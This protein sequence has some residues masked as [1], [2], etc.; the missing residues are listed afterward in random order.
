[1]SLPFKRH[2]PDDWSDKKIL[3]S[4]YEIVTNPKA[5]WRQITGQDRLH[6]RSSKYIADGEIEG[7]TI[8]IVFEPEDRGI[9]AIYPIN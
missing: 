9:L 8:R 4:A 6:C 2:F 7:K 3:D 5:C 1:M